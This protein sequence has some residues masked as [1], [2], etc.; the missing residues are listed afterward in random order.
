MRRRKAVLTII[1]LFLALTQTGCWDRTEVNDIA[2]VLATAYDLDSDGQFRVT[3]QLP[4]PGQLGGKSGG[5]GGTS[6]S[7]S[8]YVDSAS[9]S[10][11]RN[12]SMRLQQ[13]MPR[14]L[15]YAHRRVLVI[16]EE[17]AKRGIRPI[18]DAVSRIPENRLT[19]TIVI[20][21][22]KG[23]EI[24]N[25]QPR[26]ERFSSE[27]I[28]EIVNTQSVFGVMIKDATQM[29]SVSKIDAMIPVVQAKFTEGSE[30]KH[31]EVQFSGYAVFRDDKMKGEIKGEAVE[32]IRWLRRK[33]KPYTVTLK[34]ES[35]EITVASVFK[36]SSKVKP[37]RRGDHFH[38]Q[39]EV[40]GTAYLLENLSNLELSAPDNV[41]K[42]NR[43]LS[44]QVRSTIL[45]AANE[46]REQES[47]IAGLGVL[48]YQQFPKDWQEQYS[49]DWRAELPKAT[50]DV[51]AKV[52][53]SRIGL[54]TEN[55]AK[56]QDTK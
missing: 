51:Q 56:R 3:V 11:I 33:V 37:I 36:G 23:Y 31:E 26:F 21:K 22:G 30:E 54:T 42:V 13:R 40:K 29:L 32:G 38:F 25:K 47:D 28:R 50:F 1:A 55:L 41:L 8:Y 39:V 43:M 2:I 6:G 48:V 10:S 45:S 19:S 34:D 52:E 20:A 24:L 12:A 4:L 44:A 7:K 9:G 49:K 35:G 16:G 27:G 14:Q 46:I 53:I 18:F 5:G 15:F 17:L